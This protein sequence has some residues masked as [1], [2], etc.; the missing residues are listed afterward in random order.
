[1]KKKTI[2]LGLMTMTLCM[3]GCGNGGSGSKASTG[4]EELDKVLETVEEYDPLDYVTLGDYK[5]IE[6]DTSVSDEEIQTEIDAMMEQNSLYEEITDRKVKDGDVVNIDYVGKHNGEAFENGSDQNFNLEIGSG[7]FID[8][9]EEKLIGTKPGDVVDLDLTFPDPYQN[10]PELAGEPVVFTVTVNYIQ[11]DAIESEFNDEYVKKITKGEYKDTESYRNYI[12][13]ELYKVKV[14]GM[15]DDAFVQA[16]DA[17]TVSDVP[18]FLVDLMK[19]RIDAS[20]KQMAKQAQATDFEKFLEENMNTDIETYNTKLDET[21][22]SYVEQQLITEAIAKTEN[23]T[24]TDEEYQEKLKE[25]L[26][27]NGIETEEEMA[28]YTAENYASELKELINE[29]I[30]VEKVLALVGDNAVE[31]N[32]ASN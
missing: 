28:K 2:I 12:K 27:S 23:I 11:G 3:A 15:A 22:K 26:D 21:A 29:A 9:F 24:V 25:Y 7:N 13:D 32:G 16:L 14:D 8:G 10:A 18:Q 30:I 1:M 20:Y 19:L 4:N 5:G 31:I 17:A 6:V